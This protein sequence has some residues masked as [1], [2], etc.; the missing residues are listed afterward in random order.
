MPFSIFPFLS[1]TWIVAIA[2]CRAVRSVWAGGGIRKLETAVPWTVY[3]RD[4][5]L[6]ASG[7]SKPPRLR[8]RRPPARAG[9]PF[10]CEMFWFCYLT[11]YAMPS[12][13]AGE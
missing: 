9:A 4:G 5:A 7:P 1:I 10:R 2:S 6:I 3:M 13:C 8:E 12:F 11:S